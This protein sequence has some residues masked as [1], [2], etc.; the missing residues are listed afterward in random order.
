[1]DQ[2]LHII[3]F[4][5]LTAT[6]WV[7]QLIPAC[8]L[9]GRVISHFR[10][11]VVKWTAARLT[12]AAAVTTAPVLAYH[13]VEKPYLSPAGPF[14]GLPAGVSAVGPALLW[15]YQGFLTV[16]VAWLVAATVARHRRRNEP[17]T[18]FHTAETEPLAPGAVDPNRMRDWKAFL[19]GPLSR[20]IY[21]P[22]LRK[23][24]LPLGSLPRFLDGFR[25]LH[26]ADTHFGNRCDPEF[27]DALLADLRRTEPHV[28]VHTGDLVSIRSRI[29]E[30]ARWLGELGR[31]APC[32]TYCVFGNH[33]V[34]RDPELL[35][36]LLKETGC[37]RLSNEAVRIEYGDG[38][39]NLVGTE[40]PWVRVDDWN[41][42]TASDPSDPVPSHSWTL[43]L[44]HTPD[45][46]LRLMSSG[47]DLVLCGHTHGGQ[48]RLPVVGPLVVPSK[49][50]RAYDWGLFRKKGSW[51][52]I[53]SGLGSY[54]PP[55]RL[56]CP[57]EA[58]LITLKA[59][60]E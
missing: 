30:A 11:G 2:A 24:T 39:L 5:L 44:A 7:A 37:R 17:F 26:V 40:E 54:V 25:I 49:H 22:V 57:P 41:A 48:I 23:I 46:A 1:M 33:D 12:L 38:G 35:T 60:G 45:S 21:K 29:P 31:G 6:L 3:V 19:L 27:Y 8:F 56:G 13:L 59:A 43:G 4:L 51:L 58:V 52:L 50:G 28:V 47:A 36:H 15:T 55:G 18:L 9:V 20:A 10:P 34:I 32:G 14:T 42:L 53:T 16:C